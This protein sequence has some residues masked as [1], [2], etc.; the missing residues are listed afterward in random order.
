MNKDQIL[1]LLSADIAE[2]ID[3][4]DVFKFDPTILLIIGRIALIILQE[5]YLDDNKIKNPTWMNKLQ[6]KWL[7]RMNTIWEE[8]QFRDSV[9][10]AILQWGDETDMMVIQDYKDKL[11]D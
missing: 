4:D 3:S 1:M 7:I 10:Q 6:L 9:Y 8:R 11:V 2:K 5:C